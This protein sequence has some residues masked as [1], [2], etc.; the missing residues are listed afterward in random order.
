M[1]VGLCIA[2]CLKDLMAILARWGKGSFLCD[3]AGAADKY[4][5]NK[6]HKAD[7]FT[8]GFRKGIVRLVPGKLLDVWLLFT[9]LHD[10]CV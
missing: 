1:A 4:S 7:C 3:V 10:L 5:E 6:G 2:H 8:T 9:S